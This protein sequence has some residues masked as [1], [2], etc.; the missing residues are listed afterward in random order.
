MVVVAEGVMLDGVHVTRHQ[1]SQD[2]EI[3]LGGVAEVISTETQKQTGRESRSCILGHL[4][5]GGGPTTSDRL[6]CSLFGVKAVDL[7][8][9]GKFGQMVA[10]HPPEFKG[11]MI[12]EAIGRIKQI[13][14]QGQLVGMARVLGISFGDEVK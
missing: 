8:A 5:R 2:K 13:P 6:L 11:V 10:W 3:K 9:E 12:S 14:P 7:I 1:E 4:Q